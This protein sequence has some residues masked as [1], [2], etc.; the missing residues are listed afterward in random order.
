[1]TGF[2]RQTA[3]APRTEF[4]I[5]GVDVCRTRG[6][7]SCL[8]KEL[9]SFGRERLMTDFTEFSG[10]PVVEFVITLFQGQSALAA[11]VARQVG[12]SSLDE[13][14]NRVD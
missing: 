11:M 1:V 8:G 13:F 9:K 7:P 4:R 2:Q 12:R 14:E 3:A 10:V 5:F 6:T